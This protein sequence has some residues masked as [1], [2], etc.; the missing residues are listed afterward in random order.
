MP[1][2]PLGCPVIGLPG[3]YLDL[4][5]LAGDDALSNRSCSLDH[6]P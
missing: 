3:N 4:T 6:H 2:A 1:V 5:L